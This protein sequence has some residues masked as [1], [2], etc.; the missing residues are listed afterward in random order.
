MSAMIDRTKVEEAAIGLSL[1]GLLL[2]NLKK[3]A[4]V[5]VAALD[6]EIFMA[7]IVPGM[8]ENLKREL[9]A[10]RAQGHA[11][12]NGLAQSCLNTPDTK[13]LMAVLSR[14]RFTQAESAVLGARS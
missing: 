2:D 8:D 9:L 5:F 7:G 1:I 4:E 12:A 13:P 10:I 11:M 6:S 3:N 14:Q